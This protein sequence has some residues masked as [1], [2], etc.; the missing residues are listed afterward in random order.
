[1]FYH[2]KKYTWMH[3]FK[4]ILLLTYNSTVLQGGQSAT[5][6]DK[7]LGLSSGTLMA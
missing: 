2:N 5:E 4:I 3:G 7:K 6:Y 1:M